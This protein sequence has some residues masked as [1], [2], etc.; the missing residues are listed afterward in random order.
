MS[1]AV[2]R[3]C[4]EGWSAVFR[5]IFKNKYNTDY[6]CT[7]HVHYMYIICTLHVHYMYMYIHMYIKCTYTCILHVHTHVHY[8]YM[9]VLSFVSK[10]DKNLVN[11]GIQL[12]LFH[13]IAQELINDI[14]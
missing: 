2:I 10:F 13:R 6:T 5:W 1:A 8:M 7:L 3:A 11:L 4:S 14:L 9:C 12:P